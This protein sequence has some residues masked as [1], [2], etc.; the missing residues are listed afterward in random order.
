MGIVPT[1][2]TVP[3][4]SKIM[5]KQATVHR[6]KYRPAVIR[7]D[8]VQ[9]P[10][11]DVGVSSSTHS[12]PMPGVKTSLWLFYSKHQFLFSKIRFSLLYCCCHCVG[13]Y[14]RTNEIVLPLS[15]KWTRR[16]AIQKHSRHPRW[17]WLFWWIRK[18]TPCFTRTLILGRTSFMF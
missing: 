18:Q 15:S 3:G 2:Y 12:N 5:C 13:T 7:P 9:L 14:T 11:W 1:S 17:N 6:S 16:L 4:F 8:L 10:P